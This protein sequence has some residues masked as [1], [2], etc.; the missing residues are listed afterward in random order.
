MDDTLL[1]R[2][3]KDCHWIWLRG[4]TILLKRWLILAANRQCCR[5][6]YLKH[7]NSH[8]L[9]PHQYAFPV[10][11]RRMRDFSASLCQGGAT[12]GVGHSPS[13]RRHHGPLCADK[14]ARRCRHQTGECVST[15][16]SPRAIGPSDS[17]LPVPGIGSKMKKGVTHRSM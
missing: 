17:G 14:L 3:Y 11:P 10:H 12:V 7:R 8:A 5:I 6:A 13:Q 4:W 2:K 16:P 1:K 9:S 15:P